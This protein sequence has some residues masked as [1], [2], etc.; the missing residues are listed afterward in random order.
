MNM[1]IETLTGYLLDKSRQLGNGRLSVTIE[2]HANG[3]ARLYCTHWT[4]PAQFA[5]EDCKVVAAG[6]LGE[7]LEGTDH[8][9]SVYSPHGP[10][11]MVAGDI[12]MVPVANTMPAAAE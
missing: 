8:Y 4:R 6:T 7:V 12:D 11:P 10:R 3:G 1:R 2:A 9:V 5:F